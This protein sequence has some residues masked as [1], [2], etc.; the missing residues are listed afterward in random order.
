MGAEYLPLIE[1]LMAVEEPIWLFGGFAEDALLG[2]SITRHH[3][4]V[5]FLIERSRLER[6][7]RIFDELGFDPPEIRW[8]PVPGEPLVLGTVRGELN[9][10]LSIFEIA[11]DGAPSFVLTDAS[12]RVHR[13]SMPV[14]TFSWP[15]LALE[16]TQ[17]RTVSPLALYQI[18]AALTMLGSLGPPRPK[19]VVSQAALQKRFF[20]DI[21]EEELQPVILPV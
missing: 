16:H 5:D 6:G 13:A 14:D 15:L 17:V 1:S 9:L 11:D 10:E 2:G 19:D 7:L 21:A 3:D 20:P 12:G 18:R 4:D 8:E